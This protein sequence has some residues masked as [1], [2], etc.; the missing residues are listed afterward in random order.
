MLTACRIFLCFLL[1]SFLGWC[2]ESVYCSVGQGRLVNRG[3]LNGPLCPV[4]GFGALLVIFLLGGTEGNAAALFLAGMVVTSLLEYL[5][6]WLL[7]KLFHMKW[8]DYSRYHF[9]INGRVCLLNSLMFGGL[10]V[11][12]MLGL[13]P[14]VNRLV[15]KLPPMTAVLLTGLLAGVLLADTFITVRDL[16]QMKGHLDELSAR[17]AELHQKGDEQMAKLQQTLGEHKE[18]FA[19]RREALENDWKKAAAELSDRLNSEP[20]GRRWR[21]RRIFAAFPDLKAQS[22]ELTGQLKKHFAFTGR[23]GGRHD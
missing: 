15:E 6:S 18:E 4:Y 9:Q 17:L 2:C 21:Q 8:W 19:A 14:A 7:E 20:A 1:Y 12:L 5:T 16:L 23:R 10:S 11:I 13:R 3:F 22:S